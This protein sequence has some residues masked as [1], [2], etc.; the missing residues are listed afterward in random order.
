MARVKAWHVLRPSR[1]KPLFNRKSRIFNHTKG[2]GFKIQNAAKIRLGRAPKRIDTGRL[3]ASIT[4]KTFTAFNGA[5]AIRVGTKVDYAVYV[6]Q[7]TRYMQK[8]PF[9]TDAVASVMR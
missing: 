4:V 3:R 5:G 8:N 2:I 7:G 9:M 6:H 1:V